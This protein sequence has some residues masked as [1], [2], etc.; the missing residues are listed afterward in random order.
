MILG[1]N[2]LSLSMIQVERYTCLLGEPE[3]EGTDSQLHLGWLVLQPPHDQ[4]GD[5]GENLQ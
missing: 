5:N 1:V 2:F 4:N 3:S